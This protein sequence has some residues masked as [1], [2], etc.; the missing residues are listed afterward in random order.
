MI[1]LAEATHDALAESPGLDVIVM[2]AVTGLVGAVAMARGAKRVWLTDRSFLHCEAAGMTISEGPPS[3]WSG[4]WDDD[5]PVEVLMGHGASPLPLDVDADLVVIRVVPDRL[6]MLQLLHGARR[7]LRPGGRCFVAGAN[8][9]GAKS[10]VKMMERLFGHAL[11]IAQH[12]GH[13][14]AMATR[15]ERWPDV[16]DDLATPWLD[17]DLYHEIPVSLAGTDFTLYTRPGVF[18]WEHLDEAT[19]VLAGL[20]DDVIGSHDRVLDLG[21]GAGALGVVAA[22]STFGQVW[23]VDVD[24]EAVRCAEKTL[25]AGGCMNAHAVV[26]DVGTAVLEERFDVVVANPP[27]HVGKHT[28]LDVPHQFIRDAFEVL[29]ANGKLLLVANRTLPY[30][31]MIRALFGNVAIVHDGRR[32]KVLSAVKGASARPA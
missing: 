30:E 28:D 24:S 10:A 14:M 11:T 5:G 2:P 20:M 22:R 8:N 18:S 29:D 16:P 31:A 13:R 3:E 25:R 6:S 21:C 7:N 17:A 26:S 32:F 19:E 27:F 15:P 1:M 9:E 23:L 4:D 12:S